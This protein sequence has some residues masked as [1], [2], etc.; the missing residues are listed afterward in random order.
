MKEEKKERGMELEKGKKGMKKG[1]RKVRRK[2]K[3]EVGSEGIINWKKGEQ[4]N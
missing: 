1:D 4:G 2:V 3:E